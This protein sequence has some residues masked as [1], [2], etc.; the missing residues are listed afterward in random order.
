MFLFQ[1]KKEESRSSSIP[2]L[3]GSHPVLFF[4][5]GFLLHRVEAL[6][7]LKV[8]GLWSLPVVLNLKGGREERARGLH[9]YNSQRKEIEKSQSQS[10][11]SV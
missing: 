10:Q 6:N 11:N 1:K 2:L 5:G 7:M 4:P 8:G 9:R 3:L